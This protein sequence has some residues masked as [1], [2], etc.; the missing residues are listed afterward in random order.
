MTET[1]KDA[2][3]YRHLFYEENANFKA[4]VRESERLD[5]A[6]GVV[7]KKY[8]KLSRVKS[9]PNNPR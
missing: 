5:A 6:W 4:Y 1:E 8:V 3:H 2:D 7:W 9:R